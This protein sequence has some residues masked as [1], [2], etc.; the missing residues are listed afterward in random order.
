MHIVL[1]FQKQ[2]SDSGQ[3]K[4]LNFC[5]WWCPDNCSDSPPIS[6]CLFFLLF[7]VHWFS[8]SPDS[9]SK[10]HIW[11]DTLNP[12]SFSLF[13]LSWSSIWQ[14]SCGYTVTFWCNAHV[15]IPSRSDAVPSWPYR[16]VLMQCLCGYT[17]MSWCNA[18]VAI[19]S[20]P[21]A[22][23]T[24]LYRHRPFKVNIFFYN[25]VFFSS[26]YTQYSYSYT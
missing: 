17:V 11:P 7:S 1:Q 8:A 6:F 26:I 13:P 3:D 24:W 12:L 2:H 20:R 9:S 23:L 5:C 22:M 21:A 25:S 14:C 19:L 15:A 10:S 16:H 4:E 18:F